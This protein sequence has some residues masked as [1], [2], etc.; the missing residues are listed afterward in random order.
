MSDRH[1]EAIDCYLESFKPVES[2]IDDRVEIFGKALPLAMDDDLHSSPPSLA[3]DRS[4]CSFK[5]FFLDRS[6]LEATPIA[7]RGEGLGAKLF[8]GDSCEISD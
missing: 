4:P 2:F 6:H 7:P 8:M 1:I 5:V 3:R